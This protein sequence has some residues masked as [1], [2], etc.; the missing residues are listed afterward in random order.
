M[1]DRAAF[2]KPIAH[3]GLHGAAT[4]C[5][6]NTAEAFDAALAKGY[7]IECDLRPARCA[8]PMVF[9][10]ETLDR[11]VDATGPLAAHDA[12]ALGALGYRNGT[13][14]LQTFA[15][16]LAQV[17]GRQPILAEIKSEWDP[18]DRAFLQAVAKL[19]TAYDGPLA[20]MS[21]DPAVMAVTRELAPDIPRGIVSGNIEADEPHWRDRIDAERAYRLTNLLE[22]R[23]AAPDFYAYQVGA[24]PTAVTRYVREVL[25]LP[26]FTWTVR[27]EEERAIAS[28]W[29]DA[30]IFEGYEP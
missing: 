11:L 4:G 12:K 24:L 20:L 7:G 28:R 1:R 8:T 27:T 3:R 5:T 30:P 9:H 17:A 16:M 25:D 14:R 10:D 6:E 29:A 15:E 13:S 26:L 18:P 22:S 2:L 21:F 19:A 23:E